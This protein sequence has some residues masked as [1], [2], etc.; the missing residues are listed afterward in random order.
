MAVFTPVAPDVLAPWLHDYRVGALVALEGIGAGIENSNFFVTTETGRFVLTVF[1]R[2]AD[3]ELPFYLELM[4]HLAR[5]GVPCPA[6]LA[7][8]DGQLFGFLEGKPAAMVTCLAGQWIRHPEPAHCA[9][10]GM[11]MAQMHRAGADFT[12]KQPN[13]RG[14]AW[15]ADTV[16]VV[17]P[18]LDNERAHLLAEEF[19][20]LAGALP[21][22]LEELPHGPIH[23]DL[24]RDNALFEGNRLGGFIDFYF[25]GYD[26]LLFDIA[27]SVNDWCIDLASGALDETRVEAFLGAYAQERAFTA[28]EREAWPLYLRAAAFRFWLSRLWDVHC[29]RPATLLVPHDPTHFER[30]LRARRSTPAPA[31]PVAAS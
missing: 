15:W 17:L 8:R 25:A 6:P 7:R 4:L 29:P 2:L 9:V 30:V 5:R 12:L 1:E 27:V 18:H 11:A 10:A 13:L 28:A 20:H 24:F 3:D 21:Q 23:A 22:V 14:L 19:H 26:A 16:P 31:L